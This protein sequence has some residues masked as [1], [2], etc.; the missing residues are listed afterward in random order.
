MSKLSRTTSIGISLTVTAAILTITTGYASA[1]RSICRRMTIE[2]TYSVVGASS[3]PDFN[4]I[5]GT[6]TCD[7]S[8]DGPNGACG[9][10]PTTCTSDGAGGCV[11][12]N[13]DPINAC[14][15]PKSGGA[16]C[17]TEPSTFPVSGD[18]QTCA[19]VG[20]TPLDPGMTCD[21]PN[22]SCSQNIVRCGDRQ[23][24]CM[25]GHKPIDP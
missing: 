10:F 12:L 4:C 25:S 17:W 8:V 16:G 19:S 5:C 7:P 18:P 3:C 13:V 21:T 9:T 1:T 20:S 23:E 15:T 2:E 11:I 14:N 6:T 24:D 22:L